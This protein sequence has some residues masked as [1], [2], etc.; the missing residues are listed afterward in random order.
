MSLAVCHKHLE[1]S[2]HHWQFAAGILKN[3][4]IAGILPNAFYPIISL[5]AK[6]RYQFTSTHVNWRFATDDLSE[7]S[8]VGILPLPL[9]CTK[10]LYP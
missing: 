3:Q 2:D 4:T 5:I 1:K 6:C 8:V 9:Y 10:S 7:S